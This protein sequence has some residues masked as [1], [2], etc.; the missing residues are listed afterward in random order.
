MPPNLS[1]DLEGEGKAKAK[2]G[3]AKH[4]PGMR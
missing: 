1:D 3:S 4:L 2:V